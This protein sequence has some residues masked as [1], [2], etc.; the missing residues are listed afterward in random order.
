MQSKSY[1]Q[2]QCSRARK[3]ILWYSTGIQSGSFLSNTEKKKKT[4]FF[5]LKTVI[6]II[7]ALFWRLILNDLLWSTVHTTSRQDQNT[8]DL[9]GLFS[10]MWYVTAK[11]KEAR[12]NLW[13]KTSHNSPV[14]INSL[15]QKYLLL[16]GFQESWSSHQ[17]EIPD[18][19][20]LCCCSLEMH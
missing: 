2:Q 5:S 8:W 12:V 4:I 19:W 9:Q 14:I 1:P 11:K 20:S 7:I 18:M 3:L 16:W 10:Q 15:Q 6:Y 17:V 13:R